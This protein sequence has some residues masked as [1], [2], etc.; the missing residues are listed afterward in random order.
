MRPTSSSSDNLP[1]RRTLRRVLRWMFLTHRWVGVALGL[2][3]A[4]WALS[5][6]VMMYV[7]YPA[8]TAAERAAGLQP[9][10]LR[11][12][13]AE[14]AYPDGPIE[15]ATVEMLAG[16]PVLRWFG[17]D[18]PHLTALAG[19]PPVS[20]RAQAAQVARDYL[21]NT[22][23]AT[24]SLTVTPVEVDQW[25][26]QQQAYA[27]LYQVSVA[28]ARGTVLYISGLTG[29]VVQDTHRSERLWN[30]LGAVPHW[31]YFTPLRRDG[32]AWSQVVIW[33]SLAGTLLTLTGLYIGVTMFHWRRGKSPFRGLGWWHHWSGLVFGLA[34]LTFVFSGFASMQPWGWLESEG[35]GPELAAIAGRP[36]GS[37]DVRALVDTLAAHPPANAVSAEVAV[38]RGQAWAILVDSHGRRTRAAL[39]TLAPA[40]P[41]RAELAALAAAPGRVARQGLIRDGDAYHYPHHSTPAQLPAWRAI[42]ADPGRTR[43]YLDPATGEVIDFVD[44]DSRQFRWWHLALHRLDFGALRER[45]LW[46]AV[47]LLLLAGVALSTL[48]GVWMG[49][50]R[51]RRKV[52]G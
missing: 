19:P 11:G 44:A 39:A 22:A 3:M 41:T 40:P 25:T 1:V 29:E 50:R 52:R 4:L 9:L 46:D 5:G 32:A 24:P 15:R 21:R 20:G 42:Y 23:G 13:C 35:P 48:L 27:P 28:D 37:E 7:S 31:L 30:W 14:F 51:V 34:T 6:F 38:Q 12:C 16:Q 36:I 2:L 33:T 49:W 47:T 10:D 8:T 45:P 43:L 26:L 17:P 18:G